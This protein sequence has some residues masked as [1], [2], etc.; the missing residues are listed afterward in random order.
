[1]VKAKDV[2]WSA[3]EI[4]RSSYSLYQRIIE[5]SYFVIL[6]ELSVK[7]RITHTSF[8][9]QDE[10]VLLS[11]RMDLGLM[12]GVEVAGLRKDMVSD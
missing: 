10:V 1:M 3:R 9:D 12:V 8:I 2:G 6:Q 4:M 11:I 7:K 5:D